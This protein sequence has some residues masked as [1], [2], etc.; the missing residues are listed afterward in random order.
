MEK[1]GKSKLYQEEFEILFNDKKSLRTRGVLVISAFIEGQV[2]LLAKVFLEK[3]RV[4]YKP[5]TR[6]EYYQSLNVLK[7]NKIIN[8]EELGQIR[9]FREERNKSVHGIFKGMTRPEWEKQNNKV[10]EL[11]RPIVKNLDKKLFPEG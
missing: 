11:G 1:L 2:S 8:S 10:V 7:T 4:V 9:K 5:E 3:R 6:Q